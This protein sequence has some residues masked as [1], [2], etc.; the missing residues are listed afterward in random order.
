MFLTLSTETL[1]GYGLN[2]IFQF[3][4][5]AGFDGI[6]L[7]MD[8][9]EYDTLNAD[10]I[11]QLI[12]ATGLPIVSIQTPKK[13]SKTK[14]QQA[15][16]MAQ[17]LGTKIIVIQP[18]KLFDVKMTKWLT[19]EIPKIRQKESI[20]IAMEN[21]SSKTMLGF[22]PEHGMNTVADLKKFKHVAL[23]TSRVAEKQQDLIKI[24]TSLKKYLVLVHLSNFYKGKPYAPPET[25]TLPL[26]SFL[27]K[28]KQDDFKG[29]ISVK[30]KPKHYHTGNDEKMLKDIK[31]TLEF[32]KK[33]LD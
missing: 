29:S 18:P 31:E 14:I 6:D 9:S 16:K 22:I 3:A 25:G 23:D 15:V 10:Y 17:V 26:E 27:S 12:E 19:T 8:T 13:T 28:L 4:K 33:Y 32:C 1:K 30:V 11:K 20:S 5:E 2:R 21:A 24:Y 7:A